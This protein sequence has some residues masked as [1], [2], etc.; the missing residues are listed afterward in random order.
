MQYSSIGFVFVEKFFQQR[1]EAVESAIFFSQW[2]V[3]VGTRE[4]ELVSVY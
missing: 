2:H 3:E 4:I 1:P